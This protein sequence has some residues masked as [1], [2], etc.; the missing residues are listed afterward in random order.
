MN[1]SDD[2]AAY[3]MNVR[4]INPASFIN[5][6]SV[7]TLLVHTIDDTTT[8]FG[9]SVNAYNAALNNTR[10][11]TALLLTDGGHSYNISKEETIEHA[12]INHFNMTLKSI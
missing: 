12:I 1:L 9:Q 2:R 8:W 4:E 7:P 10:C 11:S 6:W 5:D 3:T